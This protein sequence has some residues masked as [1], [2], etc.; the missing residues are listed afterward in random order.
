MRSAWSVV[1][2]LC[3]ASPPWAASGPDSLEARIE[4]AKSELAA[5]KAGLVQVQKAAAKKFLDKLEAEN[6]DEVAHRKATIAAAERQVELLLSVKDRQAPTKAKAAGVEEKLDLIL[7]KLDDLDKRV[8][9]L[10]GK[11]KGLR[12]QK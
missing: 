1:V 6:A 8:Q 3:L 10:E 7:K 2:L 5:E 12:P 11:T 9:K 4:K